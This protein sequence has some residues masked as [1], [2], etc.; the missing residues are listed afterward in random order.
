MAQTVTLKGIPKVPGAF[1]SQTIRWQGDN[2]YPA[3]TGYVLTP[4]SFGFSARIARIF[5]P[6]SNAAASNWDPVLVPT[7][8]ATG[9][10][11]TSVAVRLLVSSTGAEVANAVNVSAADFNIIA[12]GN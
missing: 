5:T 10:F 3:S 8:D 2:S 6:S 4:A 7:Y 11:I 1:Q 12:E 9:D